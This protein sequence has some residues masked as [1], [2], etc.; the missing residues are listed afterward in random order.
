[1]TKKFWN[2]MV[3]DV[4][5]TA[6]KLTVSRRKREAG[7]VVL[8]L[9]TIFVSITTKIQGTGGEALKISDLKPKDRTI[10]D[11]RKENGNLIASNIIVAK[12]AH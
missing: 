2:I 11:Y 7:K 8:V 1:M 3:L 10:I 4:D 9:T 12:H 6:G 5:V